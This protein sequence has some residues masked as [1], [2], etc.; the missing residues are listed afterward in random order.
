M[1]W[2]GGGVGTYE[3]KDEVGKGLGCWRL[4]EGNTQ[5]TVNVEMECR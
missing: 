5:V 3:D 2:T 1:V 4:L